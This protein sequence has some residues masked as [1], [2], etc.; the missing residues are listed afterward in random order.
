MALDDREVTYEGVTFQFGKLL[1]QEA[2]RVF[3]GHVRPLLGGALSA[4]ADSGLSGM[5]MGAI[6]NAPQEHYDA[7]MDALYPMVTYRKADM[8]QPMPLKNGRIDDTANAFDGMDMAHM[9]M[10]DAQAFAVNFLGSWRVL[11]SE[12]P[13]LALLIQ[14][15]TPEISTP[16]FTTP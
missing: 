11:Q 9:L 2:K 12:F 7:I 8:P 3:M 6:V 14:A 16:S 1:P 10:I 4:P 5:I 15:S 13:Q